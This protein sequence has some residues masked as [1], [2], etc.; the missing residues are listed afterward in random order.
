[1]TRTRHARAPVCTP[2]P[3]PLQGGVEHMAQQLSV[4]PTVT[5]MLTA[6]TATKGGDDQSHPRWASPFYGRDH[7]DVLHGTTDLR[8]LA[9]GN[10]S[11]LVNDL[12]NRP[13][14]SEHRPRFIVCIYVVLVMCIGSPWTL[15]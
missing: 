14:C 4:H 11:A 5:A 1:M 15:F 3:F 2:S 8:L 10:W 13:G 7:A 6:S 12:K 9:L